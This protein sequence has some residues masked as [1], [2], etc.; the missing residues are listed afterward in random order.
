MNDVKD[1]TAKHLRNER[2]W[3]PGADIAEDG[4]AAV[5]EWYILPLEIGDGSAIGGSF[6]IVSLGRS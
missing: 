1:S 3:T 2:M 6:R 5:V 4:M